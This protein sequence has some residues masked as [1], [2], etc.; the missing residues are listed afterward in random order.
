MT[1]I[2]VLRTVAYAYAFTAGNLGAIIGLIWIPMLVVTVVGFVAQTMYIDAHLAAILT[3]NQAAEAP[4]WLWMLFYSVAA[5]L[6]NAMMVVPVFQQALGLRKGNP[7]Y[8]FSV[9]PPEW[10]LFGAYASL[11]GL[12]A[13]CGIGLAF[14]ASVVLVAL[15]VPLNTANLAT[16]AVG[17][18]FIAALVVAMVLGVAAIRILFL[19]TAAALFEEKT[20]LRRSWALSAGNTLRILAIFALTVL[21]AA[22]LGSGIEV[23]MFGLPSL[24]TLD[25]Q[26]A[27]AQLNL[28]RSQMPILYALQFFLAPLTVGLA[29]GSA[30]AAYRVLVPSQKTD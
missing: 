10:R 27:A 30:A 1:K 2:P 4:G 20:V 11:A 5:L 29:G 19:L 13:L 12:F 15:R 21:P 9:G 7:L 8:H 28:N 17:A 18:V 24:A 16:P 26:H 3:S 23:A 22:L 14:L 25:P 6:C